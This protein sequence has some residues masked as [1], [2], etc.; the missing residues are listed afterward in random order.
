MIAQCFG[1]G[2][3]TDPEQ[4]VP[5]RALWLSEHP[6]RDVIHRV[7]LDLLPALRTIAASDPSIEQAQEIVDFSRRGDGGSWIARGVLLADGN[8]RRDARDFVDVRLFHPF[9]ELARVGRQ[10][11]HIAPL[12]LGIYGVEAQRR[13]AGS[14]DTRDDS[15]LVMRNVERDVLKVVNSRSTDEY[16]IFQGG[17]QGRA[18]ARPPSI[19]NYPRNKKDSRSR[20]FVRRPLLEREPRRRKRSSRS[21]GN[22]ETVLGNLIGVGSRLIHKNRALHPVFPQKGIGSSDIR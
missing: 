8:G 1:A 10:R 3:L 5:A 9:E 18:G 2:G 15:Q 17:V 20:P 6:L 22:G 14:G 13:L 11:L 12:T 21:Y 16:E 19:F 4:R 7:A